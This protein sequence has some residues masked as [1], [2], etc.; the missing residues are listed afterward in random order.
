[1]DPDTYK[2]LLLPDSVHPFALPGANRVEELL[3]PLPDLHAEPSW[4]GRA[5]SRDYF[6]ARIG[7]NGMLPIGGGWRAIGKPDHVVVLSGI[8][9]PGV[10]LIDSRLV[11]KT[12]PNY[13]VRKVSVGGPNDRAVRIFLGAS[14][15]SRL[16]LERGE[17]VLM[18]VVSPFLVLTNPGWSEVLDYWQ[19]QAFKHFPVVRPLGEG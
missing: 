8:D 2:G 4:R 12:G 7:V 16:A 15:M 3:E 6:V 19:V 11:A 5:R 18:A 17:Q 10:A 14:A 9:D 1:M 13:E